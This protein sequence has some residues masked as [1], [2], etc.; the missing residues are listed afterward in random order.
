MTL[1]ELT[2]EL[3]AP[4][5][6]GTTPMR[7]TDKEPVRCNSFHIND[8]KLKYTTSDY[9][10]DIFNDETYDEDLKFENVID[11][12]IVNDFV[13]LN[14]ESILIMNTQAVIAMFLLS[15]RGVLLC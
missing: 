6:L 8:V 7:R 12:N 13:I 11:E 3:Y 15:R 2:F 5:Q 14:L 9:V 1:G 10:K 4:N